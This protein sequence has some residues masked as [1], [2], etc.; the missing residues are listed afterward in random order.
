ML[1]TLINTE[2]MREIFVCDDFSNLV[3]LFLLCCFSYLSPYFSYFNKEKKTSSDI[4]EDINI[5]QNCSLAQ[6][7]F[8]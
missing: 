6:I 4:L 3:L 7:R 5:E 1:L 2:M 8:L